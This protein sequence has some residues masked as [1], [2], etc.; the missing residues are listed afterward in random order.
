M[1]KNSQ[2]R[3]VGR[4]SWEDIHAGRMENQQRGLSYDDNEIEDD[5]SN[6]TVEEATPQL[7]TNQSEQIN[8]TEPTQPKRRWW[9][10][11]LFW[12]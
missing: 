3:W 11:L 2:I 7:P 8:P 6:E 4:L 12:R 10:R 5:N 1:F 9:E